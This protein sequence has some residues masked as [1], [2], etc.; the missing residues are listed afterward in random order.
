M[1]ACHFNEDFD[2]L[3]GNLEG[4][5]DAASRDGPLEHR[6]AILK[7]WRDWNTTEGAAHDVRPSLHDGFGVRVRFDGPIDGRNFMNRIYDSLIA[8]VRAETRP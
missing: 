4:A 6:R 2:L 8:R 7:E 3:Y 5:I 1:L